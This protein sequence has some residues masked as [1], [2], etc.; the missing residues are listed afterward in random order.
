MVSSSAMMLQLN[1]TTTRL[2][3]DMRMASSNWPMPSLTTT[4]SPCLRKKSFSVLFPALLMTCSANLTSQRSRSSN[5]SWCRFVFLHESLCFLLTIQYTVVCFH[6]N[7]FSAYFSYWV[8]IIFMLLHTELLPGNART[9][10]MQF[11]FSGSCK[12]FFRL[13]T[14]TV[15]SCQFISIT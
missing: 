10:D 6:S 11:L 7:A 14:M 3:T 13:W 9:K 5:S 2:S 12:W 8:W 4:G 15:H 1:L